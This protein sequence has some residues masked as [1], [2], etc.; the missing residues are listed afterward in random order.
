MLQRIA[1]AAAR[2]QSAA[3]ATFALHLAGIEISSRHLQRLAREIGGALAQQRDH[4]ALHHRRRALPAR[5][6]T[7]PAVGAVE[8]DGGR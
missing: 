3:E 4:K 5:V 1:E 8:V 7:A 2:L 6:A